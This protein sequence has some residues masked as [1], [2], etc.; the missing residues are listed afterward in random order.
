MIV[1]TLTVVLGILF[2][3]VFVDRLSVIGAITCALYLAIPSVV[4]IVR[5]GH[6][7]P[8]LHVGSIFV[9]ASGC[10]VVILR[11]GGPAIKN[12]ITAPRVLPPLHVVF[13]L[14][15]VMIVLVALSS[16]THV[17]GG[18]IVNQIVAPYILFCVLYQAA[19]EEPRFLERAT[20][21]VVVVC[22]FESAVSILV[23]MK[24]M[25]QPWESALSS[26]YWWPVISG[27]EMGTTDHPLN[28]GLLLAAG[29]PFLAY[30]RSAVLTGACYISI[31]LAL[32]LTESRLA[33]IGG[34]VASLYLI[35]VVPWRSKGILAVVMAVGYFVASSWGLVDA[36]MSRIEDD[37]GSANA[38]S[39]AWSVFGSTWKQFIFTGAGPSNT[40]LQDL[41]LKTSAE[42]AFILY[43]VAF[44]ILATTVYFGLMLYLVISGV[45]RHGITPGVVSA[46][47]VI[48]SIQ[49]YS[50]IAYE[51]SAGA[52]MW[53]SVFFA[54]SG[55][56]TIPRPRRASGTTEG[57]EQ[58]PFESHRI[59]RSVDRG[60]GAI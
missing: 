9:I 25:Q 18:L 21:A 8:S 27:R 30:V 40:L 34:L 10:C 41:G 28:L 44:G 26:Q 11:F 52:I 22:V 53:I 43:S 31:I 2:G 37:G 33:L 60:R 5:V 47:I 14:V 24:F 3:M 39:L 32:L 46:L 7:L 45:F 36:V 16:G 58:V 48:V 15:F 6:G 35:A 51:S 17:V 13:H 56:P 20:I 4:G 19:R 50:S 42:S 55:G 49:F 29:L 59:V 38:R 1:A 23:W 54:L 57:N 12:H